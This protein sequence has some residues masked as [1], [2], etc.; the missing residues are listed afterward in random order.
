MNYLEIVGIIA[1]VATTGSFIP[2]AYKVYKTKKTQDLSAGMFLLLNCGLVLWIIYGIQLQAV[3]II[4]ANVVTL[5]LA[6][7]ILVMKIKHG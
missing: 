1:G 6:L 7:Y 2:Q 3:P 4:T 5:I